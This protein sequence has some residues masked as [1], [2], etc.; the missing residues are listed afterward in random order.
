MVDLLVN[1]TLAVSMVA[2][3]FRRDLLV[4]GC[5]DGQHGFLMRLPPNFPAA[6]GECLI[7]VRERRSRLVFGRL[8]R[9]GTAAADAPVRRAAAEVE[10]LFEAVAAARPGAAAPAARLRAAFGALAA[11]LAGRN[12]GAR[13]A[14]ALPHVAAPR[15]TLALIAADTQAALPRIAALAPA[16][17]EIGAELLAIDPTGAAALLPA[18]VRNLRYARAP[19]SG[20]VAA[21]LDL[22]AALGRG[23]W[24][25]LAG[26]VAAPSAAALLALARALPA[27]GRGLLVGAAV[28]GPAPDLRAATLRLPAPLG[29][30]AGCDRLFWREAGTFAATSPAAPDLACAELALRAHLLG[31]QLLIVHE[32]ARRET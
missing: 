24:L 5:G 18:R 8:L 30:V 29:F 12:P 31:V 32:P 13:P 9:S 16:L 10:A 17:G 7:T 21:A 19:R 27:G 14:L 23:D 11:G 25:L 3:M 28:A 20:G 6:A 15:L 26:G 22:A 2:A 4:R 1:D